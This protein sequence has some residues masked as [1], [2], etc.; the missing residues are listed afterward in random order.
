[1]K[2]LNLEAKFKLQI[3]AAVLALLVVMFGVRLMGKVIDFAYYEREHIVAITKINESLLKSPVKR[4]W[5]VE[6]AQKALQ[7]TANVNEAVFGVEKLLFRL[8][9]QGYLLD[10]V[11]D[12]AELLRE[13]LIYLEEVPS[14]RLTI[15]EVTTLGAM[16]EAPK[17]LTAAFGAGL[18][19]AGAF[20]KTV[21]ILL[22]VLM[23]GGVIFLIVDLMRATVNPLKKIGSIID[24][25]A[26][27]NLTVAIDS[28][29][30]GA[31]E[32]I[33]Q[34]AIKMV[35]GLR[36][37]VN[38]IDQ[39]SAELSREASSASDVTDQTLRGV[40]DQKAET[41]SL[42]VA[43]GQM[44]AAVADVA[45]SSL[46]AV[47]SAG[48]GNDA[49]NRGK[50]VVVEVV[51]SINAL[52][53]DVESSAQAIRRIESDSV[54]IGSVIEMIQGITEQ[55]NLLAL[56]AAIEAARAGEHG[57]GFAVV[58]DEVRTLAQRTQSST[59]EIQEMIEELRSGTREAV[60]IMDRSRERAQASVE[61]ANQA[62]CVIEEIASSV[63]SIEVLNTQIAQAAQEQAAV[64][65]EINSNT[66]MIKNVAE[67]TEVGGKQ[68]VQSNKQLVVLSQRLRQVVGGFAL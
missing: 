48:E 6:H 42:V 32:H 20:V 68:A 31:V 33:N 43:L 19:S 45:S 1:M 2:G 28:G 55:T 56:N 46:R 26:E 5:V 22:V 61:K 36:K 54:K 47:D 53:T 65:D 64:T 16:M 24:E 8:L 13:V 51:A 62:G 60:E 17:E 23:L 34:A 44:G 12:D 4:D 3:V 25:I 40:T 18:R 27:G 63:S 66:Q 11:I 50:A 21:V 14:H 59:Q 52:A 57:R 30:G 9:G 35:E 67:Q 37:A 39:A 15:E 41:D 49:A 10:L 38:E 29:A 58:A 7:Q